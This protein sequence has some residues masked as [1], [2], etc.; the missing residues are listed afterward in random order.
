MNRQI[1]IH[2]TYWI[3]AFALFVLLYSFIGPVSQGMFYA[4][5]TLPLVAAIAY[6]FIHWVVPRLLFEQRYLLFTL[7]TA[8]MLA[9]VLNIQM[10]VVLLHH[11]LPIEDMASYPTSILWDIFYLMIST[12]L[13]ALPVISYEALRSWNQ[14]EQEVHRLSAERENKKQHLTIRSKGKTHRI[15]P[16][17]IRYIE[18]YGDYAHIH[19][20]DQKIITRMSLKKLD[21]LLP[22]CLRVHRSYMV[23]SLHC[24]AFTFEE[25]LVDETEIPIGRTFKEE[26]VGVLGGVAL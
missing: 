18:S 13:L 12:I 11:S 1:L 9:G 14:K 4:A 3:C 24:R 22:G 17:D 15:A 2:G 21:Q 6:S 20:P 16:A 10:I 7:L 23:N 19:L 8:T 25:I 26:V 5:L